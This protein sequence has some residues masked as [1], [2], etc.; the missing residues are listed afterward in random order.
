MPHEKRAPPGCL[1]YSIASKLKQFAPGTRES[2]TSISSATPDLFSDVSSQLSWRQAASQNSAQTTPESVPSYDQPVRLTG[3]Y[4]GS[5]QGSIQSSVD[6]PSWRDGVERENTEP[7]PAIPLALRQ[8]ARRSGPIARGV[9]GQQSCPPSTLVRQPERRLCFVS[10]LV[11]FAAGLIAAIWPLSSPVFHDTTYA[12]NVLPLQDFITETLRRS[13]TSYST[14]QVAMFYLILLKDNLPKCDFTQ[15]QS[16][17][18]GDKRSMQ[19]GRRMFLSALMLASKFLQDRNYSTRA[20]GKIT[21]LATLEINMNELKFLDAV[22]WKLHISKEKFER[23]SHIVIALSGPPKPG[24]SPFP[25]PSL[26]ETLGWHVV[27]SR[28]SAECLDDFSRFRDGSAL[29]NN[30][31]HQIESTGLLTPPSSPP[32]SGPSEQENTPASEDKDTSA[33]IVNAEES[34]VVPSAP[35]PAPQQLNLPTPSGTPKSTTGS[36]ASSRCVMQGLP[37]C[38]DSSSA[39]AMLKVCARPASRELCPPPSHKPCTSAGAPRTSCMSR[40][41]S[42]SSSASTPSLRSDLSSLQ[43]RSRSSSIASLDSSLMP[44]SLSVY[45][46]DPALRGTWQQQ[47]S[48]SQYHSVPNADCSSAARSCVYGAGEA[49]L[50]MNNLC[51]TK[52]NG[53]SIEVDQIPQTLILDEDARRSSVQKPRSNAAA[54]KTKKKRTHSKTNISDLINIPEEDVQSLVR[55][56]LLAD[57]HPP[58]MPV[59]PEPS[60]PENVGPRSKRHRHTKEQLASVD[61]ARMLLN[62]QRQDNRPDGPVRRPRS[63]QKAAGAY[64]PC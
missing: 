52:L 16:G 32:D 15:E 54:M 1:E 62:K 26:V 37:R 63:N 29:P 28:L 8:N 10:S 49:L 20:W 17:V 9:D 40:R 50:L 44:L 31:Y 39:L 14:L 58:P 53:G 47:S 30:A 55:K 7:V 64:I 60:G 59:I 56:N 61:Y 43:S 21:G 5:L 41:S 48:P 57:L 11:V 4:L 42:V 27:L 24:L 36:T 33:R 51:P 19:C 46:S 35:P 6:V 22:N 2:V 3:P 13:K 45:P 18:G 34:T 12:H 25:Q 23:W 38:R